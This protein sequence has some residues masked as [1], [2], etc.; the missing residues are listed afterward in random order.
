MM[1]GVSDGGEELPSDREE[2]PSAAPSDQGSKG[3]AGGA[4]AEEAAEEDEGELPGQEDEGELLAQHGGMSQSVG[5][6]SEAEEG[7]EEVV[8]DE[9]GL[10]DYLGDEF[11][12]AGESEGHSSEVIED[13]DW[14]EEGS[15]SF[16][17]EAIAQARLEAGAAKIASPQS[18]G[19][20]GDDFETG[21]S[22]G[23][24]SFPAEDLDTPRKPDYHGAP[25]RS[26]P[27]SAAR[28]AVAS[29]GPPH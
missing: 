22:Y 21:E 15:M 24:D 20:Y 26:R 13:N 12:E 16:G 4:P 23:E 9:A 5:E 10:G 28:K 8:E 27:T 18:A 6:V 11:A 19:D 17:A 7:A 1:G 3:T 29:R 2:L 14:E 25:P